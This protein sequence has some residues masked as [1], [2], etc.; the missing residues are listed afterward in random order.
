MQHR[1]DVLYQKQHAG[2][3]SRG[4][5]GEESKEFYRMNDTIA[6]RKRRSDTVLLEKLAPPEQREARLKKHSK[7]MKEY[8][9][10][11][12]RENKRQRV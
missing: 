12:G 1:Y 3:M 10:L 5:K 2:G 9:V 7:Y 6:A 4:L 11:N 8:R